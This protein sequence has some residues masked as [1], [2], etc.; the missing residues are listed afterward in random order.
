MSHNLIA[1]PCCYVL[2][3]S[4][5]AEYFRSEEGQDVLLF[6]SLTS[7]LYKLEVKGFV[8]VGMPSIVYQ[9]TLYK[10]GTFTERITSTKVCYLSPMINSR[11]VHIRLAQRI[12]R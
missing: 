3:I 1:Q 7:S 8:W 5:M 10:D 9:P 2:G 4:T 12:N 11:V 6:I